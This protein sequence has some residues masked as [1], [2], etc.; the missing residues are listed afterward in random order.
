MAAISW[1]Y[2]VG[3]GDR[4]G[5]RLEFAVKKGIEVAVA[6]WLVEK[7]VHIHLVLIDEGRYFIPRFRLVHS[8]SVP[9]GKEGPFDE[10]VKGNFPERVTVGPFKERF[11]VDLFGFDATS[12]TIIESNGIHAA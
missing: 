6:F 8:P 11:S 10:C 12:V 7:I 5:A 3:G 1:E 2:Q 4:S 9:S